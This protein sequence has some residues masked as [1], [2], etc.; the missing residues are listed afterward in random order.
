MQ[1]ILEI[2]LKPQKKD[3]VDEEITLNFPETEIS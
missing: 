2:L 1:K 3:E